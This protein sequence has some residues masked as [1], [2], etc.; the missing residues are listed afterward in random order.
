M[1]TPSHATA[2]PTPTLPCPYCANTIEATAGP[3]V[4]LA[5]ATVIYTAP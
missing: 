3:I 4:V 2:G 1:D 5:L